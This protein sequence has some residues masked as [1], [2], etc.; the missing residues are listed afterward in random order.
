MTEQEADD[1]RINP[2]DLTGYGRM[3][4]FPLHD[5][6]VL[7]LNPQSEKLFCRSQTVSL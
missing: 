3:R 1:Y 4:T 5:V 7:E 6:G 2:F